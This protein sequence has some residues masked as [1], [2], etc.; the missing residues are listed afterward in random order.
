MA[1]NGASG[2]KLD[3]KKA[4]PDLYQSPARPILLTVPPLDFIMVEGRGDPNEENGAYQQAVGLLYALSYTVKMSKMGGN[5]PAG[6]FDYVVPPLEGLW[7][8]ADGSPGVD[9]QNKA[10]FAW[11]SMIRQPEFVNPELFAWACQE[12]ARKKKLDPSPARLE[13]FD[14]GL[15]VQCLHTGAYDDEPGTLARMEAFIAANGLA[16]DIG[17]SRRH[18]EIY[19]SDP[20]KCDVSRLKTVVRHPIRKAE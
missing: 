1:K 18:H 17:P 5:P 13:R 4:Y 12:A 11:I 3:Y 10:G 16:N 19:L 15:C 8:M 9:Y 2:N 6:Y 14:E 20:R 7:W